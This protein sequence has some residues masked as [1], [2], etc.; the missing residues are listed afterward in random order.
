MKRTALIFL[1]VGFALLTFSQSNKVVSAFNYH[2]YGKLDQAKEAIDEAVQNEKTIGDAKAWFYR[3]NIYLDIANSTDEKFRALDPDPLAVAY[4]SYQRATQLDSKG[5]YKIDIT[6]NTS[7]LAESYYNLAVVNYNLKDFK[8]AALKFE[9]AFEVNQSIGYIDTTSM[10]NAAVSASIGGENGMAKDYYQQLLAM[11]YYRPDIYSSLA[12]VYKSEGD[13]AFAL[14][15]IQKGR[16]MFPED[17]N[18][19][20][21]ETNIYLSTSEK[22][23]AMADLEKALQIDASNPSIFFAV[24]TIY[25]QMG[26]F[27]KAESAY[28]Q[29]LLLNPE[30][31]EA[32]YNIGAL[33]VNE[34]ADIQDKA[35]DLPLEAVKEYEVEKAKADDLLKESIPY[36]EKALELN[37][38]DVNAMV[39]LKEIYTRLGMTEK[40][41]KI[42]EMLGQ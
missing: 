1:M 17:F 12:E 31:F 25:D 9:K 29:A 4:E 22:E 24:G 34:A 14:K 20:I 21:A 2:R 37:P 38:E 16:E 33:Y 39:S 15:T 8:T 42:N 6:K 18:L 10:Y 3:G 13:T 40:L 35:N 28:K 7:M 19:L 41:Q 23:K 30:Y 5:E 27:E 26:D 32:N 36:L 11:K